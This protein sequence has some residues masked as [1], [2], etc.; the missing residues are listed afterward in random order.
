ML[1]AK[2]MNV[3][4]KNIAP[5]KITDGRQKKE[6]MPSGASPSLVA[7]IFLEYYLGVPWA[8]LILRS[9]H[10]VFS[11]YRHLTQNMKTSITQNL[12]EPCEI[13]Q[14]DKERTISLFVLSKT[15]FIIVSRECLLQ[16]I[17]STIY[18]EQYKP[19]KL[20]KKQTMH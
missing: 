7:W 16:H 1:Q 12:T 2:L 6:G 20:G 13:G 10:S 5:S 4:N 3:T 17:I 15:R 14:Y 9:C 19:Q 8:S 18:I 11:S